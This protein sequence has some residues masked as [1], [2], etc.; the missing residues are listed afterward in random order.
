MLEGKVTLKGEVMLEGSIMIE[1]WSIGCAVV[2]VESA[3]KELSSLVESRQ[4]V[5]QELTDST[6]YGTRESC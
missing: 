6:L 5:R 1:E 4:I 2:V 3:F